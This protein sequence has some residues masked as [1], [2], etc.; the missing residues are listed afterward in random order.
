M[1]I[2][3]AQKQVD[4]LLHAENPKQFHEGVCEFLG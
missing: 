3:N 2:Q 4:N 1:N